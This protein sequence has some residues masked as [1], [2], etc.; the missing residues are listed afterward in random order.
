MALIPFCAETEII[1]C[2]DI[3]EQSQR[4]L[5]LSNLA[6]LIPNSLVIVWLCLDNTDIEQNAMLRS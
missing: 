6:K 5:V 4:S 3:M 2:W 1:Q